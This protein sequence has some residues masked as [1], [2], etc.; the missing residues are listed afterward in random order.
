MINDGAKSRALLHLGLQRQSNAPGTLYGGLDSEVESSDGVPNLPQIQR[1]PAN[2]EYLRQFVM[3]GA[4]ITLQQKNERSKA[5]KRRIYDA[6]VTL[7]RAFGAGIIFF[8]LAHPY[9][10][11]E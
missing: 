10:K 5:Y 8:I 1:I 4:C 7:L 11:R 3:D 6:M 9:I 2:T